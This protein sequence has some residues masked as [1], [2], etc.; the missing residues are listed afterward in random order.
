MRVFLAIVPSL[1][2]KIKTKD[3]MSAFLQGK[4]IT[5]DVYVIPPKE[6]RKPNMIWKLKKAVYGLVD[7][8]RSWYD[9]VNNESPRYVL[10][11]C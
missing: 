6:M 4:P 3:V 11:G 8:A 7:A 2:Y 10:R 1:G 5:R 9:S